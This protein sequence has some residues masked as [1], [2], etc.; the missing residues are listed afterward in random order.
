[1]TETTSTLKLGMCPVLIEVAMRK[2]GGHLLH[3]YLTLGSMTLFAACTNVASLRVLSGLSNP[4][5]PALDSGH[6]H[7][8]PLGTSNRSKSGMQHC[9]NLVFLTRTSKTAA[10]RLDA[11][12]AAEGRQKYPI[13]KRSTYRPALRWF[14]STLL[15][16]SARGV[17]PPREIP[18]KSMSPLASY[19]ARTMQAQ[20]ADG[21]HRIEVVDACS[22][23]T[24]CHRRAG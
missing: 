8:H 3:T 19:A 14:P 15:R 1:M 23:A 2:I 7:R 22:I 9:F 24:G 21:S 4:R 5:F 17:S 16:F 12:G 20:P 10:W 18:A 6:A 11:F 13:G